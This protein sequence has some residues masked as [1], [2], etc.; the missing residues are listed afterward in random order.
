[1]SIASVLGLNP[2]KDVAEVAKA[3]G[4]LFTSDDERLTHGEVMERIRQQP[5]LAQVELNKIEA[6]HRS[7]FIAG[8]RPFIGWVCGV[9]LA[10]HFI[11]FPIISLVVDEMPKLDVESLMKLVIAMLGLGGLR[12]Y[13]KLKGVSK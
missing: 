3:L 13:E 5:E 9:G 8:W 6:A 7:V 1:V 12:T 10:L 11:L 2:V 4:G